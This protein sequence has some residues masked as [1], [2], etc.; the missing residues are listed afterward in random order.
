MYPPHSFIHYETTVF[1]Q[2]PSFVAS[3]R[4]TGVAAEHGWANPPNNQNPFH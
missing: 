1:S 3:R 2:T 4:P